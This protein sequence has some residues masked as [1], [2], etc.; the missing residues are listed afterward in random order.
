DS[1]AIISRDQ[2]EDTL[3][4]GFMHFRD[5]FWSPFYEMPYNLYYLKDTIVK[6]DLFPCC[7]NRVSP[8]VGKTNAQLILL[9]KEEYENYVKTIYHIASPHFKNNWRKFHKGY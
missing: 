9:E 7:S 5:S 1:M 3:V 2:R 4:I 8:L 6:A